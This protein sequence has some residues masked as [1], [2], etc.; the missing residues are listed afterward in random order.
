MAKIAP[1]PGRYRLFDANGYP[2]A[3]WKIYT[4]ENKTTTF[5]TTFT[6]AANTTPN[7]NPVVLN[8]EGYA[9]IWLDAGA[10]TFEVRKADGSLVWSRDNISGDAANVFGSSVVALSNNT[11]ITAAYENNLLVCSAALTLTLAA[12]ADLGQGFVFSVRNASTGIVTID[13][14]AAEQINGAATYILYPGQSAIVVSGATSWNVI[15]S[16]QASAP[17]TLTNSIGTPN[18]TLDQSY[19]RVPVL[20][21]ASAAA[22]SVNLPAAATAGAGF[23]LML[24]KADTSPNAIT[25]DPNGT[26]QADRAAT[27]VLASYN[28]SIVLHSDGTKWESFARN[29]LPPALSSLPAAMKD[30]VLSGL[31]LSNNAADATNDIDIAAGFCMSDDGTTLITLAALTKQL[32]AAWA[33]GTAAGGRDTGA[34][35]DNFWHVW[36]IHNPATAVSDVLFS[37]SDT[38]PTLPAGYTKKKCIG[39]IIRKAGAIL[40]FKQYRDHFLLTDPQIDSNAFNQ[41]TAAILRTVSAPP[42]QIANV[43]VKMAN[44]SSSGAGFYVLITAVSQIDAAPNASN[45]TWTPDVTTSADSAVS[46]M[47]LPLNA[48]S[49]IRTRQSV[50]GANDRICVRTLGWRDTR[51]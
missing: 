23:V 29:I 27:I 15:G 46:D 42:N 40:L 50:S 25:I 34:I 48:L 8:S 26:E 20:I 21:D 43:S 36:A 30:R 6:D 41:G 28:D 14:D 13:P 49:Q 38:A 44:G 17:K 47:W 12:L 33:A 3:G 5:K 24:K 4:Y 19:N 11:P 37:L 9:D 7:A 10:Y 31:T 32:D 16:G 35:A 22:C 51:L 45:C 2:A 18:L 39:T 1:S